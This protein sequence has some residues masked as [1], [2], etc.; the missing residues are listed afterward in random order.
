MITITFVE[1]I[2]GR[3]YDRNPFISALRLHS[4]STGEGKLLIVVEVRMI[5]TPHSDSVSILAAAERLFG[6]GPLGLKAITPA[7]SLPDSGLGSLGSIE[8]ELA[9]S[10]PE[11]RGSASE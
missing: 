8:V 5:S 1:D 6:F 4:R 2:T 9:S 7:S 3:R 10:P 11:L